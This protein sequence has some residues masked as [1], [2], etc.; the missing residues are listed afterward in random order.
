MGLGLASWCGAKH[1]NTLEKDKLIRIVNLR[2]CVND[3]VKVYQ[4]IIQKYTTS[5]ECCKGTKSLLYITY[6]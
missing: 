2:S 6:C 1:Y 3:N 5:T 4:K